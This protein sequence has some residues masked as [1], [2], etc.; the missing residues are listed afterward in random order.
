MKPAKK[1]ASGK[2]FTAIYDRDFIADLKSWVR[3]NPKIAEIIQQLIV[4][5]QA[6]PFTGLGKPEPLRHERRGYW[7]RRGCNDGSWSLHASLHALKVVHFAP[8]LVTRVGTLKHDNGI[9][10]TLCWSGCSRAT[11]AL[12]RAEGRPATPPATAHSAGAGR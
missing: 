3:D 12:P 2:S 10:K 6:T 11:D 5:T 8:S 4:S 9:V 1:H 7:S